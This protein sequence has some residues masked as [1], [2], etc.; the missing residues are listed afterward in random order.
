MSDTPNVTPNVTLETAVPPTQAEMDAA[1]NPDD[2]SGAQIRALKKLDEKNL[3]TDDFAE[4]L[5]AGLA[6]YHKAADA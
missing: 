6:A 4:I 3:D 1:L 2:L 5:A